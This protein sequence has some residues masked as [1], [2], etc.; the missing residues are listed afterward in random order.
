MHYEMVINLICGFI[1][2]WLAAIPIAVKKPKTLLL[3]SPIGAVVSLVIN[4]F[5]F[6]MMFWDFTPLI[7]NDESVSALP[8]DV[9]LYPVLGS[10]LIWTIQA[11]R[12]KTALVLLLFVLCTTLLEYIGILVGKVTYGNGWNVGFTFL[13]YLLAFSIVYLYFKLLERS[14]IV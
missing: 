10:Y 3:I 4:S 7:P 9:G 8:L 6:Q 5:G 2:P 13:S 12:N 1:I 14:R 11:H